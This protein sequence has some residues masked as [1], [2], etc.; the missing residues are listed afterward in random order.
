MNVNGNKFNIENQQ[1][2]MS[3]I[4]YAPPDDKGDVTPGP[5]Q[6]KE[7]SSRARL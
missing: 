5:K 6:M 1:T 7:P 2:N 4:A 3:E